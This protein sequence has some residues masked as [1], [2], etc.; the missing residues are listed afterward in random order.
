ML[1]D[2]H[3]S[4]IRR[5]IAATGQDLFPSRPF[6][7]TVWDYPEHYGYTHAETSKAWDS[8]VRDTRFWEDLDAYP[9]ADKALQRLYN[10]QSFGHDVYFITGRLG[11]EARE[12][13]RRWLARHGFPWPTVLI[14]SAKGLCAKALN[15]E[16]Y[17]DD[18]WENA[19]DVVDQSPQTRTFLVDR[20]W[21]SGH[22]TFAGQIH[23]VES[24]FSF[25]QSLNTVN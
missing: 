2:F 15:L 5:V 12:Q 22:A 16:Y 13:T 11:I 25:V 7:I 17:V 19:V 10:L 4:F 23:R 6:D 1:A 21:N 18:K 20:P 24:A 8:V 14:S 3:S 9:D